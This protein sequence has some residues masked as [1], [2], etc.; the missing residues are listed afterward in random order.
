[1]SSPDSSCSQ[2]SDDHFNPPIKGCYSPHDSDNDMVPGPAYES[3]DEEEMDSGLMA[4]INKDRVGKVVSEWCSCG[5][6]K[7]MATEMESVC[8]CCR[9]S[10]ILNK[11][12]G[13]LP[14][15]A[16]S[17]MFSLPVMVIK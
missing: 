16:T 12:R 6:Y 14:C 3:S 10:Y 8:S 2:D 15:V 5:K 17:S 13:E 11:H 1:M 4:N 9:E 7:P